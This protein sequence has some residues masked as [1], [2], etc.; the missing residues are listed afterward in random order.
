MPFW[1]EERWER[2]QSDPRGVEQEG[3]VS[4]DQEPRDWL[5]FP[6]DRRA[7]VVIGDGRWDLEPH[8]LDWT[9]MPTFA[10]P[11][12]I[13]RDPSSGLVVIVMTQQD[14]CF[15]VFTPYGE[16]PH[17]SNYMSIF[18]HDIQPG[19]TATAR[20]RLA[21]LHDSTEPQILDVAFLSA[22]F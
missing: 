11:L 20:S 9:L 4:A 1:I 2:A 21:V 7:S 17:I 8:P 13:R 12:A 5:A 6:R 22:A 18:G 15:G 14:D 19:E 10:R 16:E 3:F